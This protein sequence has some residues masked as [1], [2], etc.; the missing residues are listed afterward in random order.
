[1]PCKRLDSAINE[2]VRPAIKA[3]PGEGGFWLFIFVDLTLFSV[4]FLGFLYARGQD[5][6]AFVEAQAHV[7]QTLGALNTILVLCSSW[8]VVMAIHYARNHL[9]RKASRLLIAATACGLGFVFIKLMEYGEKVSAGIIPNTSDFFDF[10]YFLTGIH[11][12]HVLTGIAILIAM[13]QY[14][15][16]NAPIASRISYLECGATFWHL[17]DLL[18]IMLFAL[19]YLLP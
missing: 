19:L 3:F 12:I 9:E 7:H 15:R 17:V 2:P 18:W 10:Y 8:F 16:F 1:M 4:F 5:T 6:A 14:G 11:F 13:S